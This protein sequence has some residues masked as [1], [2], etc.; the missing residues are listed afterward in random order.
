M[1]AAVGALALY[2]PAV[3][4]P[5]LSIEQ[6][7][8]RHQSSL[9][10]GSLELLQHGHAFVGM[11][12]FL[13]SIVF[14]FVKILGLLELCWFGLLKRKHQ[15]FMYRVMEA[16]ARWSMLDVMLLA[17]LVMMIKLSGLVEFH[18]GPA[19]FAFVGCVAMNLL[20]SIRF[21]PHS[22]WE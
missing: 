7:G 12:V 18:L 1:A 19:V 15:A 2:F 11:I 20:A 8:R 9:L 5:I 13:F 22:I 21:D 6:L 10:G 14:P 4:L 3:L 17:L 16:M